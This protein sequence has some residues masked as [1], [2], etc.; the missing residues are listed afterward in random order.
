MSIKARTRRHSQT[1]PNPREFTVNHLSRKRSQSMEQLTR[2]PRVVK[3][4]RAEQAVESDS[5]SDVEDSSGPSEEPREKENEEDAMDTSP[6]RP[7]R[8]LPNSKR[9]VIPTNPTMVPVQ[10]TVPPCLE[11][12]KVSS[13]SGNGRDAKYALL[14]CDDHQGILAKTGRDIADARPDITHQCLLTLLDSPLNKAGRL[15]VY[16]HTAKG[17]LIE[18]NPHVRIPRTFKRFSGLMVQLLHRLSIRGVNGSEKLLKVIKNPVTD[19]FPTNTYKITLSGDSQTVK[20][21]NYLPTLPETHSIAV[22]VGAMARG[23]DDFADA[24]VDEKIS[25]SDYALSAS[26]ACGKLQLRARL[27]QKWV[28]TAWYDDVHHLFVSREQ[29]SPLIL[30]SLPAIDSSDHIGLSTNP[31]SCFRFSFYEDASCCSCI[32]TRRDPL[33]GRVGH[34]TPEQEQTLAQF[35]AE[36]QTEG[37]FV[38]SDMMIPHYCAAR[39]VNVTELAKVTTEERQLQNLVLEYERFLH[40]RLP[41]CS[42]AAGAP[43]ETSC[44]ILDLKGVG[45]GSFF[46]V[47]D[48]VMKASAIGQNYYPETMGKFY[49]INTPFMFSTVWNVIKPWLDP[50]TV[51]KISIP[52]SSAT[53]KEL[54]AQIP[55]ENLPADLGGSCNCPGGCSLSDQGPWNDPKYK[56]MAKNKVKAPTATTT[57]PEA[58]PEA[59]PAA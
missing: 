17:V 59:T 12:Y 56:D 43:V 38:P 33:A 2:N 39:S 40:E 41:A 49:I 52:S 45:I 55:K 5:E 48:Y 47:K 19:H 28:S 37:H 10:A 3:V 32:M 18:I 20:L 4:P 25:I 16:V 36:L 54:L 8:P 21:S 1:G 30:N 44:T 23:K 11:A 9:R 34:L 42:A 35:K 31:P 51:A 46:S 7:T 27:Y 57:A 14:N 13:N 58:T 29:G 26:V 24:I 50:V 15:Q 22:F 53:E 6:D